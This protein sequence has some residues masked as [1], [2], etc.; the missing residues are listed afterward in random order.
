MVAEE[1]LTTT[2]PP[3]DASDSDGEETSQDDHGGDYTTRL[4][5]LLSDAEHDSNSQSEGDE[6]GGFFYTGVDAD[7]AASYKEQLR[8]VLGA[9][10]DEDEVEEVEVEHSLLRE[11]TENEDFAAAMEDEARVSLS[12]C[13]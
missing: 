10:H 12:F 13:C 7:P 8:S 3:A 4:E 5:E 11:V 2:R 1:E 6:E 9:D